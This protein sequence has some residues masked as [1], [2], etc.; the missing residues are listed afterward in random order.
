[1]SCKNLDKALLFL[2]NQVLHEK[3]KTLMSSNYLKVQYFLL[4]LCA[5]FLLTIV[6]RRVFGILFILFRSWVTCKNL[7][8]DLVSTHLFFTLILITQD[9]KK[10]KK[11]PTQFCRHYS[12]ENVC[13]VSANNHKIYGS[14]SLPK[15]LIFQTKNLVSWK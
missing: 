11:S 6:Y 13:K 12:V 7:K 1:M 5:C 10:I 15:L 8:K 3:L 2:R 4:K 9:L 14:W